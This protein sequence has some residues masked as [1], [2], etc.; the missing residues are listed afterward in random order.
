MD[1]SQ[2]GGRPL[3]LEQAFKLILADPVTDL[4]IVQ[5]DTG[6][7][8]MQMPWEDIEAINNKFI[9]LMATQE[10]PVVI[11]LPSGAAEME[12]LQI[13]HKLSQV[14][15]PVFPTMERAAKAIMNLRQYSRFQ[16]TI[17]S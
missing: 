12:R 10:K 7:L 9:D 16:A 15:I 14:S 13:E 11:V 8:M 6:I 1:V 4:L 5:E 3:I 17:R 2:G